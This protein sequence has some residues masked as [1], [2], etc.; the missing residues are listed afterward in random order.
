VSFGVDY[1]WGS[2]G[3]GALKRAGAV[4]ACRY[5]SHDTTGKNLT[6]A[7]AQALSAAG[8]W[9]VVVWED[10]AD[11]AL[12]GYTAGAQDARAAAAQAAACGMPDDRPVYFA[13]DFDASAA[14]TA[15]INSYLD[16]T[17]SVLGRHRVGI[18]A[19]YEAVRAALDGGHAAWAWQTYAWSS[20][21]WDPRARLHQY[22]NDHL[23]GGIDLDYDTS[24]SGDYGQWH[25]LLV[26]LVKG[27]PARLDRIVGVVDRQGPHSLKGGELG[28][29]AGLDEGAF[30]A[31]L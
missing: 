18:Y 7:E 11:R 31:E 30:G 8:M 23:I 26:Q 1:A 3:T 19:G 2:P 15:A 13:V 10:T 14:Q 24:L 5:L 27:G 29:R 4:F 20:G 28:G 9:I 12:V 17:A 22:S 21:R 25:V 6:L 16:G